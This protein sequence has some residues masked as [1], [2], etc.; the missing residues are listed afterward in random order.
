MDPEGNHHVGTSL[1]HTHTVNDHHPP[2]LDEAVEE[3][4]VVAENA[5]RGE[6]EVD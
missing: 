1:T 5:A 3:A 6:N 2:H 4:A